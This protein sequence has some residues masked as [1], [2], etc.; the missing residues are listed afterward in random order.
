MGCT[1]KL[2]IENQEWDNKK[3]AGKKNNERI[4]MATIGEQA[5]T[6]AR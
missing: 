6:S 1:D 2:D 3:C 4:V 5:K